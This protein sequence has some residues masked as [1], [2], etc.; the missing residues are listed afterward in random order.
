MR[1]A[2]SAIPENG[3]ATF[4]GLAIHARPSNICYN[5]KSLSTRTGETSNTTVC[6][7]SSIHLKITSPTS[8]GTDETAQPLTAVTINNCEPGTYLDVRPLQMRCVHCPPG[9]YGKTVNL[10]I[11]GGEMD[12]K[13]SCSAC[14]LGR[15]QKES[16][17]HLRRHAEDHG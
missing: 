5:T 7:P 14:N 6:T 1:A 9:R 3:I 16:G 11:D 15:Y 10:N 17:Q 8:L 12:G 13:L 4:T 2:V